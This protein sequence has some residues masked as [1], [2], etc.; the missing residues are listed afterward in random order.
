MVGQGEGVF[1]HVGLVLVAADAAVGEG[2]LCGGEGSGQLSL[3]GT[4]YLAEM[5]LALATYRVAVVHQGRPGLDLLA[6]DGACV[7]LVGA[8]G[9][10]RCPVSI[11]AKSPTTG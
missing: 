2:F 8:P 11:P 1:G 10:C 6:D 7:L 9:L 5:L 3:P 4:P